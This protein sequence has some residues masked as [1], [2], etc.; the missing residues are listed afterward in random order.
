MKVIVVDDEAPARRRLVR[1]LNRIGGVAVVGDA[2]DAA[3]ARAL[4]LAQRP[5][6]A[7]LDIEMPEEDGLSLAAWPEMPAIVFVTAHS[8]HAVRAFEM[9][10][11]DYLLK[12]VVQARLVAALERVRE[13]GS[14][15]LDRRE[16]TKMLRSV[17]P[18]S[19][20]RLTA[21]S[22]STLHVFDA[23]EVTRI[24]ARDK[25]AAFE[26]DGEEYLLDE[27]LTALEGRLAAHDFIRVHRSAL[28]NLAHVVALHG[29]DGAAE[30]ELRDGGRVAVSRRLL[31][32]LRRRLSA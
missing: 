5:D 17:V 7:L 27:S 29:S 10:A 23:R 12:P 18:V 13:R 16:L 25:Y 31:P 8:E 20:P 21:R 14:A 32:E 15:A 30:L 6:V 24:F 22:G 26:R 19:V 4:V 11:V 28:V 1:M 9:A 2:G 3:G